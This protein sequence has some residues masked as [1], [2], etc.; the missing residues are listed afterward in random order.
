M[1]IGVNIDV[2]Q[3]HGECFLAAP[4]VFDVDDEAN[5]VV[6]LQD[7]PPSNLDEKVQQA[8][9]ACPVGAIRIIEQSPSAPPGSSK[10]D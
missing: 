10:L 9:R 3:A 4:E 8:V 2:C 1:L 6:L 7:D 5:H